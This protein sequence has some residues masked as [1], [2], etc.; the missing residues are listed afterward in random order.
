MESR[1]LPGFSGEGYLPPADYALTL[2]EL[3]S[4]VLVG[5]P[6]DGY[7][8]W[9]RAWR[10]RLVENLAILVDELWQVG[11]EDIFIDGSFV[12]DKEHP[13]DIDGYF[14][15]DLMELASG[16]LQ[17]RLNVLD[18]HK[19]W[20]WDPATRRPYRVYPKKQLP[21]WHVYRVE[22]Y[23]HFGQLCGIRD[24]YDNELEFPSAFRISRRD[25][26]PRG[27]IK[28]VRGGQP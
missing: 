23:P 6:S 18:P 22:L 14:V 27:I 7:P 26:E 12:E 24:R 2:E 25:G 1:M 20:T 8:N 3:R 5:G 19:V 9:D 21:M 15:C 16:R 10:A 17:S 11:I 28:I 13:N 4:S